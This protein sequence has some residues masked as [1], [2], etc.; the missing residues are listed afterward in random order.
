MVFNAD[1]GFPAPGWR[2]GF[3]VIQGRNNNGVMASYTHTPTGSLLQTY[4]Y[5]EP[6]G[7]RHELFYNSFNNPS[8]KYESFDSSYIEFTDST[9][10]S[11]RI[12]RLM[13]GTQIT[14]GDYYNFQYMP[15]VIK[16]RNGNRININYR[17]LSNGERVIDYVTD[18]SGRVIEFYYESNQLTKIRQNR[19]GTYNDYVTISWQPITF[20][21]NFD[22]ATD[23][24]SIN[25]TTVWQP[26]VIQYPTGMNTRFFYTSYG[27]MYLIE[28]WA[29]TIS[30]QGQERRVAYTRYNLP[31]YN[32]YSAPAGAV[33]GPANNSGQLTDA[34]AFTT[35]H[36]WAE[37]WNLDGS[38]APQEATYSYFFDPSGNYSAVTDPQD[39]V[40]STSII[41]LLD[42]QLIFSGAYASTA[43][44]DNGLG[45][46]LKTTAKTMTWELLYGR[47]PRLTSI[48][49]TEDNFSSSRSTV[50]N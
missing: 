7:T 20:T 45:T 50:I 29:P 10:G 4:I 24:G 47:N 49:V 21:T 2:I 43:S 46:P 17:T 36:E 30:G 44:Y 27:Q 22:V 13:D 15:T 12:M 1:K 5:I 3:G 31:S 39:R 11:N 33:A 48:E 16:D 23:P 25:G 6:D 40:F 14:F 37:N 18:T 9:I 19:G 42:S 41:P 34:P 32:G 8:Q 26:S 35:R 38:G 28:K